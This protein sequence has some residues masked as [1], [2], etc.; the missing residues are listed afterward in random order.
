MDQSQK[1]PDNTAVVATSVKGRG[2]LGAPLRGLKKVWRP[3]MLAVLILVVGAAGV[4]VWYWATHGSKPRAVSQE[5]AFNEA[6]TEV[7]KSGYQQ[8]QKYLDSQ[9]SVAISAAQKS[10]VYINK[11]SLALNNKDYAN[12]LKYARQAETLHS[13]IGSAVL[14][15]QSA[16]L[17]GDKTTAIKYYTTANNRMKQSNLPYDSDIAEYTQKIKD[18]SK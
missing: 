11:A 17:S 16:E 8:G 13:T 3:W 5:V 7:N 9:L 1:T 10:D 18:L 12:A 2:G 6:L 14:I 4:G 15:A